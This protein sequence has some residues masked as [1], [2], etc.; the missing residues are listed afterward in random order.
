ME[1]SVATT[2]NAVENADGMTILDL[3]TAV[4]KHIITAIVTLVVVL[5]A[6]AGYTF[7]RTP[8]YTASAQLLAT[9]SGIAQTDASAGALSSGASY[10]N[11][12]IQTYPE[13]VKTE[14]VLQPV[15]DKLGLSTTVSALAGEVTASNPKSTMLVEISVT[16]AD[17]KKASSIANEV[18]ESLKDQITAPLT[19]NEGVKITSPVNLQVVQTAYVP[20][21]PSSPDIK[22]NFVAGLAGGIVLGLIAAIVKDLADRRV[23]QAADAQAIIDV[24]VLG[25][26]TASDVYKEKAPVIIAKPASPEAEEIRRLRTNL[27]FALPENNLSNVIVVTSA[28]QHEGKTI[29]SVNLATAFAETGSSVLLIDADVRSPS[30]APQLGIEGNVG[31][32][33][34]LTGKLSAQDAIQRYWKPNFHVLPAGKQSMNPSIMLNSRAMKSLI[35]Q[36]A[37]HYDHVI[38]DTAPMRVANDAAV[39]VKEGGELLLVVGLGVAE[40][41]QLRTTVQELKTLEIETAG[42]CLNFA[43]TDKK[44]D[45]YYY[46]YGS[47][48]DKSKENKPVTDGKG[49]APAAAHSAEGRRRK[50]A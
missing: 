19:T 9:Y 47:D 25:T 36:V 44:K 20:S 4:K 28:S 14:A 3:F 1:L 50:H 5:A 24:P 22:A 42:L 8:Q 48:D 45:N 12:Q 7:T 46:Y 17:A 13:L 41:K 26:L 16:D 2:E 35:A 40:K 39:F 38:I 15:I 33:H 37:G 21:S 32:T 18:A 29:T 6:V 11:S 31:L 10:I 23:R 49:A 43:E 30:V 27:S 34:L